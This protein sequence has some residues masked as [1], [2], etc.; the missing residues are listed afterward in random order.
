MSNLPARRD[1]ILVSSGFYI[2]PLRPTEES[3]TIEAAIRAK[4]SIDA[5]DIGE[6]TDYTG[7]RSHQRLEFRRRHG[8]ALR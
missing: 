7:G 8:A 6:A 1:I 4:V 2:A 5:I 3:D